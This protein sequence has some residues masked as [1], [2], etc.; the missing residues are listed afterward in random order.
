MVLKMIL[1]SPIIIATCRSRTFL[2]KLVAFSSE[3]RLLN[4]NYFSIFPRPLR[5]KNALINVDLQLLKTAKIYI[6]DFVFESK[7]NSD[8]NFF[9]GFLRKI[10]SQN[11][12]FSSFKFPIDCF[13]DKK[14]YG[15]LIIWGILK[16]VPKRDPTSWWPRFW[17]RRVFCSH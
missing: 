2:S 14:N 3:R 5:V 15:E 11:C 16:N 17:T 7:K 1:I 10:S 6:L 8:K 9:T 12:S 13:P 4:Q